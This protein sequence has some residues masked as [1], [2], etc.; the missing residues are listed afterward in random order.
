[1]GNL[2]TDDKL[3]QGPITLIT[4]QSLLVLIVLRLEGAVDL[5]IRRDVFVY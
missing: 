2:A 3:K 1:M 5:V 4:F